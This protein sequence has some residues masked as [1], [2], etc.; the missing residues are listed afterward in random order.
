MAT[1]LEIKYAVGD[2]QKLDCLLCDA[3]VRE[4]MTDAQFRYIRMETTYYDTGDGALSAR[5][6]TYRLRTENERSVIT[7]K[8]P[9]EGYAR[10]EWEWEGEYLDE[11]PERLLA[12]GAPEEA[13]KLLD[14]AGLQPV[15]GAKFTRILAELELDGAQCE[16]CGDIGWLLG[17]GRQEPLCELEL[18]LTQGSEAVMLAYARALAEK[19]GLREEERSKFARAR[20][21]AAQ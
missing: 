14:P 18:E 1:E 3:V 12:L 4:R 10:G 2:L 5:R 8:T 13:A 15:C 11:A 21:L 7:L 17:G 20:A 16:L 6:W 19:Y 9:G